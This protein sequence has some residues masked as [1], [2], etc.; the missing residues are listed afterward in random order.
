MISIAI[1]SK[2]TQPLYYKDVN[3]IGWKAPNF[4]TYKPCGKLQKSLLGLA[5]NLVDIDHDTSGLLK[6]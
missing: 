4:T 5:V 2:L 3:H 6:M 1:N